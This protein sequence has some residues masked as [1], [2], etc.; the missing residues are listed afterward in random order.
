MFIRW[1]WGQDRKEGM[2]KSRAWELKGRG[3]REGR[4]EGGDGGEEEREE[5]KIQKYQ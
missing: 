2:K 1:G 5:V 4:D 3:K